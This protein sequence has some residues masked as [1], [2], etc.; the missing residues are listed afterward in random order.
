M[1][2]KDITERVVDSGLLP[3]LK[4]F[5]LIVHI[6]L[7]FT[8]VIR[9]SYFMA[10]PFIAVIM[11]RHYHMTPT[12]IGLT[13]TSSALIS[14]ILGMYGGQISDRLG[15]RIILLL[16]CG[17]SAVGYI[18]LALAT[19]FGLFVTGLMII[20][21]C[22]AWVDPPVRALMSDLLVD[23]RR[24]AL[25]LQ[26][27]YY[28]INVAAV[29]GPLIGLVFG[30]TSQKGTF[31]ITGLTYVPF[32]IYVL[33]YI[34]RGRII[35]GQDA[36]VTQ[37]LKLHQMVLLIARDR[38]FIA[39]L[40]CSILCNI[41]YIHY[42]AILPQYLLLLDDNGA[43][44]LITL[45]LVTNAC[46]VLFFQTFIM[47]FL[48][49]VTLSGRIILGGIIF[50]ISQFCYFS[51]SSTD[52]W[53]WLSV[54]CLFSMGEAILMPNLNILLDQLAPPE[55]RGAY[56]GASTLS[57]LGV[58]VGPLIGGML[59]AMTGAGVFIFTAFLSILICI[60]ICACR[61]NLLMRTQA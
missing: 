18:T 9:F 37:A 52:I 59:L 12:E 45:V 25:A 49:T 28:L 60:I 50:A 27:R 24:R 57:T 47:R 7:F 36:R 51:I 1:A 34:P 22:F 6:L 56:L 33:F 35:A 58:A 61:S 10:W 53:I 41:V 19:G 48:A 14:V 42:E 55:H 23:H 15:R 31:L 40:L 17:F 32:F 21:I 44:K 43:V 29:F 5:P 39:A 13:M 11:T 46:S 30:L 3:A 20:G 8:F 2:S 54:T 16:G 26:L 38:I 4:T